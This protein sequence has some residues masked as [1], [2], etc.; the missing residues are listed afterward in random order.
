MVYGAG[1]VVGSDGFLTRSQQDLFRTLAHLPRDRVLHLLA[2]LGVD[3]LIG[4]EPLAGDISPVE[5][6]AD[7]S[8]PWEY[9]LEGR[10]PRIY[11]ADNVLHAPDREGALLRAAEPDFRPGR[12]AVVTGGPQLMGGRGIVRRASFEPG[13]LVVDLSVESATFCVVS[14]T[15][16]EGWEATIDGRPTFI[17]PTNGVMR[18]VAVPAGTHVVEMHYRPSSLQ[19]GR[20][21]SGF[22]AIGFLFFCV[23]FHLGERWRSHA[24]L[25]LL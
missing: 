21:I 4:T 10:A 20:Y 7:N 3:R 14:D 8:T 23:A 2:V 11:L 18:G 6:R 24:Q 12:D 16:F 17:Y 22:A 13:H 5:H 1:A 25:G 19:R 15:W 9:V